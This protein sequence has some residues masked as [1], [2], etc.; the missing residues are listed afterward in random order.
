MVIVQT[1][2]RI[3][4][5]GGGTDY[6]VWIREHGG[7]VLAT[8]IDKYIYTH[9]RLANPYH[10]HKFRT[11]YSRVEN[12][13]TIDE[14]VHPAVR[15]AYR[16]MGVTEGLELHHDSDIPARSGMGSSSSFM[17]GLLH[18]LHTL[19]GQHV[20]KT[21]LATEAIHIEQEMIKENVGCQDQVMAAFGGFNHIL[22]HPDGSFTCQPVAMKRERNQQ[23]HSH[24]MLF[25]TGV[26][27][28]ASDV[29][30]EQI[31]NTPKKA[32]ELRAIQNMVGEGIKILSG[33][34]PITDFG[35]MLHEGWQMKRGLSSKITNSA[36]DE[37][38]GAALSAG[39]VGGKLLGAGG[40]GF[41]LFLVPPEKQAS[42][43]S[44]LQKLLHIKFAFESRGTNVIFS[45]E[46]A[47]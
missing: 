46:Q 4:F 33:S 21:T 41:M 10:E 37:I 17:V 20:D 34:G 26:Q 29:A 32:D 18:A 45:R 43:R 14:I 30:A 2:L 12:T 15:E 44:K 16:F 39:A 7:E 36:I 22:F 24:L 1:P 13:N 6:Q 47:A 35:K 25:Y 28:M 27:R 8:S 23:L 42:V 38:Y 11:I 31:K 5:F 40:G 9:L 19:G 3:S